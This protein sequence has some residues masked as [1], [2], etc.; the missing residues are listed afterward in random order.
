MTT[1]NSIDF[2]N[3]NAPPEQ[4]K[5]WCD[6]IMHR[7]EQYNVK[8][9]YQENI[10]VFRIDLGLGSPT[11]SK[12]MVFPVNECISY[13]KSMQYTEKIVNAVVVGTDYSY[14]LL[15]FS[16][17]ELNERDFR[18]KLT[19]IKEYGLMQPSKY[20]VLF[21][22]FTMTAGIGL[23]STEAY[24]EDGLTH[25]RKYI[26]YRGK[27]IPISHSERPFNVEK[28]TYKDTFELFISCCTQEKA[29]LLFMIQLIGLT[30][31][32]IKSLPADEKR[33]CLPTVLP[34]IYGDSGCGKTTIS[35]AFF[36]A[37][38][39]ERFI[40]LSTC[41]EAA[42]Q[43]KLSSE[44]CGVVVIDDVQHTSIG[45]CASKTTEKL[46]AVIRTYGDIGAEKTTSFGKLP[47]VGAW[48]VV[49]AE[50][51]FTTVD[52]SVLRLLPIEFCRGE[53]IFEQVELLEKSR[54]E[55]DELFICFIKWFISNL[56]VSDAAIC[57]VP[58]LSSNYYSTRNTII[59]A[60]KDIS[61]A[62]IIDNHAKLLGF[63]DFIST[64]LST[65]GVT[66]AELQTLRDGII[67]VLHNSAKIQ[68]LHMYESSLPYYINQVLNRIVSE[69]NYGDYTIRGSN[70]ADIEVIPTQSDTAAY[71]YRDVLVFT[72][73]Q[74]RR[75][76]SMIKKEL[77]N[78][79]NIKDK[80]IKQSFLSMGIL[81]D[82]RND[83]PLNCII[84][85][86]RIKIN[87]KE[88]RV[89]KLKYEMEALL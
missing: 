33:K 59:A 83:E 70:L 41:T 12:L 10:D 23:H 42:V 50:S 78:G 22:V 38:G 31:E 4:V 37:N 2:F 44:F 62:R 67:D 32:V 17:N 14:H 30:F 7:L 34:Y 68:C 21:V 60:Y 36:G 19:M 85:E 76:F 82:V 89:L 80:D 26:I 87:N 9:C 58:A 65:I 79:S 39:S 51:I 20:E 18:C 13:S 35:K 15:Q 45:K 5:I 49:T 77:P 24:H 48:A 88:V 11:L 43:K 47:E 40:S 25:D 75:L 28:S 81:L 55:S 53:I 64:F 16:N 8:I 57:N 61:H 1:I 73:E 69:G 46:E 84:K 71:K 6:T 63:F 56:T 66:D 74:Q 54:T 27:Q 52:S 29:M 86:N 72:S 3:S